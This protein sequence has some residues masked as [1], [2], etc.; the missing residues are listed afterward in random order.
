[1]EV[2]GKATTNPIAVV[3]QVIVV[4]AAINASPAVPK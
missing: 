1:M 2:L 3:I 4:K